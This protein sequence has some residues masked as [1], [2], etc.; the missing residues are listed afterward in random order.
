[1]ATSLMLYPDFHYINEVAINDALR[2]LNPPGDTANDHQFT[3]QIMEG[4]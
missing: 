4:S 3:C 1:M 2:G